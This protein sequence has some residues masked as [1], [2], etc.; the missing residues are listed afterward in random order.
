KH[1]TLEQLL[2]VH[3]APGA[4]LGAQKLHDAV[5]VPVKD[6]LHLA[7]E[8]C[9]GKHGAN[10]FPVVEPFETV[11]GKDATPQQLPQ[12]SLNGTR[13]RVQVLE[14]LAGVGFEKVLAIAK[15]H[16]E[17][18]VHSKEG[19]RFKGLELGGAQRLKEVVVKASGVRRKHGNETQHGQFHPR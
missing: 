13:V 17:E 14:K 6:T 12:N 7:R 8:I 1:R 19:F 11:R 15:I 2:Q 4:R 5:P 18:D 10:D 9:S 3:G 16:E